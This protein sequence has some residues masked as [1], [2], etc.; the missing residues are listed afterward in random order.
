MP[1]TL[2]IRR[3][4][5]LSNMA[6]RFRGITAGIPSRDYCGTIFNNTLELIM[7]LSPELQWLL[8]FLLGF[9]FSV[10][11]LNNIMKRFSKHFSSKVSKISQIFKKNKKIFQ[12]FYFFEIFS[13]F[14]RNCVNNFVIN[15]C[16]CFANC[17]RGVLESQI[18]ANNSMIFYGDF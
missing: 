4:W 8:P 14:S 3:S 13:T 5:G 7:K 6:Q 15:F 16:R 18:I 17:F 1:W 10:I 9:F 12:N 2:R 11:S